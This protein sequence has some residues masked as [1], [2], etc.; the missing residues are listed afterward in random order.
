MFQII[1][2]L[3]SQQSDTCKSPQLFYLFIIYT[4]TLE[5]KTVNT[6]ISAGRFKEL[7]GHVAAV[8]EHKVEQRKKD[9]T[10][11]FSQPSLTTIKKKN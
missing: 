1:I 3:P 6:L 5:K 7:I 4:I 11:L 9:A 2:P 10:A 8:G